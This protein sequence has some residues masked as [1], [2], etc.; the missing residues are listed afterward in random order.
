LKFIPAVKTEGMAMTSKLQF[1]LSFSRYHTMDVPQEVYQGVRDIILSHDG[2]E[3][4]SDLR[5]HGKL[6]LAL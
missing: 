6:L 5:I 2:H 1:L 3:G 4:P